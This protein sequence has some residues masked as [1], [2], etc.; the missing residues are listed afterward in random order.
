[1][2]KKLN[3][4][5]FIRKIQKLTIIPIETGNEKLIEDLCIDS[6]SIVSLLVN[7][8]NEYKIEIFD[9]IMDEIDS[10]ISVNT[11]FDIVFRKKN[12]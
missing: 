2:L 6:L 10:D 12:I 1:M 11:L 3:R 7:L 9:E 5:L 8:E 4:F